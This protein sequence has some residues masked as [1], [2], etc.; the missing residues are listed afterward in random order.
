[1]D[2]PSCVAEVGGP[3]EVVDD[4]LQ[5]G[6]LPGQSGHHLQLVARGLDGGDQVMTGQ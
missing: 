1:M 6:Q 4:E 5:V 3:A 2:A